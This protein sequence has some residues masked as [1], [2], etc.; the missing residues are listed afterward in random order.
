MNM[1]LFGGTISN[2]RFIKEVPHGLLLKCVVTFSLEKMLRF[3]F[4]CNCK[5]VPLIISSDLKKK[6]Y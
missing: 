3:K 5:T 6:T 1:M 4:W 2:L